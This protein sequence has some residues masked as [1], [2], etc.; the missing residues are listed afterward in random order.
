MVNS[1][2]ASNIQLGNHSSK[3][4]SRS[5]GPIQNV[6]LL[7]QHASLLHRDMVRL[8]LERQASLLVYMLRAHR[9]LQQEQEQQ[10]Q[11]QQALDHPADHQQQQMGNHSAKGLLRLHGSS[12]QL[13]RHQDQGYAAQT[14][15]HLIKR[16]YR[17]RHHHRS[18]H[19]SHHS[20]RSRHR[21]HNINSLRHSSSS[22]HSSN[23]RRHLSS[24]VSSSTGW[25]TSWCST[26]VMWQNRFCRP[27]LAATSI[28]ALANLSLWH[29]GSQ[30]SSSSSADGCM[31][32]LQNLQQQ[33]IRWRWSSADPMRLEKRLQQADGRWHWVSV[34][35]PPPGL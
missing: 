16:Q 11:E 17:R 32:L 9:V 3:G 8:P 34:Y 13:S 12:R 26:A 14:L 33:G 5:N 1:S 18:H 4:T 22:H 2:S 25:C 20:N 7:L 30:Q 21:N 23:P 19:N 29:L 10:E 6:R 31:A 35:P 24:K 27:R 15:I 28:W